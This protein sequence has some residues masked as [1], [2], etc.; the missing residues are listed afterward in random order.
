MVAELMVLLVVHQEQ[1]L[2]EVQLLAVL[3]MAVVV[4]EVTLQ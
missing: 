3:T 4:A 2:L 1:V